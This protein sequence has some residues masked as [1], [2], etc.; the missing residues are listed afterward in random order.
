MLDGDQDEEIGSKS[1]KI[2]QS[3]WHGEPVLPLLNAWEPHEDEVGNLEAGAVGNPGGGIH[4][5]GVPFSMSVH[6][7]GVGEGLHW[8]VQLR[9]LIRD[10]QHDPVYLIVHF[11]HLFIFGSG[12]YSTE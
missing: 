7:T 6:E 12:R 3:Q 2:E 9:V 1:P 10:L 11:C 4:G 8:K 5:T